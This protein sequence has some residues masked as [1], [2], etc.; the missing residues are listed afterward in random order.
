M[1]VAQ[2]TY[3]QFKTIAAAYSPNF[4]VFF[5]AP[6][7]GSFMMAGVTGAQQLVFTVMLAP[8]DKPP[9]LA[10]DFPAAT[11]TVALSVT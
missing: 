2:V 5:T 1:M 9:T 10:A 6:P 8:E 3:D 7:N 4:T 11:E